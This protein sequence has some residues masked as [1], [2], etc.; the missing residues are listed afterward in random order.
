MDSATIE[1]S[2]TRVFEIPKREN[3]SGCLFKKGDVYCTVFSKV[4]HLDNRFRNRVPVP[5]CIK[6][7]QMAKRNEAAREVARQVVRK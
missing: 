2:V 3:C 1:I 6:A 5:E 7:R 4:I